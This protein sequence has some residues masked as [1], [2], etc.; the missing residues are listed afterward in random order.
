[1]NVIEIKAPV[2]SAKMIAVGFLWL[3]RRHK[4]APMVVVVPA[5]LL[6]GDKEVFA[7]HLIGLGIGALLLRRLMPRRKV[8]RLKR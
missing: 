8:P 4:R 5:L 1:M 6:T 3:V 7:L 2:P